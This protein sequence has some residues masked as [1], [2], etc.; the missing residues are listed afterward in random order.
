VSEREREIEIR[1][2]DEVE[3]RKSERTKRERED[4]RTSSSVLPFTSKQSP[5]AFNTAAL[6]M[7]RKS[8]G[9]SKNIYPKISFFWWMVKDESGERDKAVFGIFF[10]YTH[11]TAYTERSLTNTAKGRELFNFIMLCLVDFWIMWIF[12]TL[13]TLSLSHTHMHIAR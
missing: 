2:R 7:P 6:A 5:A 12:F 13:I 8:N 9:S 4:E 3:G 10:F 11:T 1:E